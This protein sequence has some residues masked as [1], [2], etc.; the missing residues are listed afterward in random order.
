MHKPILMLSILAG[1]A[2]F[3]WALNLSAAA[4]GQTVFNSLHC[5][6]CHKPERNTVGVSLSEIAKQ[7]GEGQK[8]V[9][10]FKG[11][12][13]PIIK[14]NRPMIMKRQ[15]GKLTALSDEDRT[16]L[17]DYILGFK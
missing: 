17:A 9:Q 15:M 16:A 1:F 12:G 2:L 3:L 8:L 7:Y 11:E 13:E 5:G 10:F 6:S 4:D 14:T